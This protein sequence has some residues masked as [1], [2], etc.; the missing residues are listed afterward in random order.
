[1]KRQ[2]GSNVHFSEPA[3]D[4]TKGGI[5]G[6]LLISCVVLASVGG[7]PAYSATWAQSLSITGAS[8]GKETVLYKFQGGAA[9][10]AAPTSGVVRDSMGNIYGTT[11]WGGS[12]GCYNGN[13]C[14]TVFKIS[15]SGTETTLYAFSGGADGATPNGGLTLD[16]NG[17]LYGITTFGGDTSA[18]TYYN[19]GCGVVFKIDKA[20]NEKVLYTFTGQG[21]GAWPNDEKL[22]IDTSGNIYGTTAI[23]G[24]FD[25]HEQPTYGCGVVFR[26]SSNGQYTVLHTF[27]G[28]PKDGYWGCSG[29]VQDARGNLYGE[30]ALGG[31]DELGTVFRVAENGKENVLHSFTGGADGSSPASGE[32]VMAADGYLYG[33]ATFGGQYGY[34][35]V[36]KMATGGAEKVLYSFGTNG[37]TDGE[38]P[39]EGVVLD[40]NGNIYGTTEYGGSSNDGTVFELAKANGF[41]ES[42]LHSFT[43]GADGGEPLGGNLILGSKATLFGDA[44]Y[45]GISTACPQGGQLGC[46][47]VFKLKLQ[48]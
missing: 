24:D 33:A 7:L 48:K 22:L 17:N 40:S 37:S 27:K 23:G 42:I 26:L 34:G 18:C 44:Q 19:S 1:M 9:D 46:G 47:V 28:E 12:T 21:D 41:A 3:N 35:V 6:G 11:Y 45:G 8:Q 32:L 4:L 20:G 31:A 25:C 2:Q 30:T 29:L 13:G 14:G 15:K 38:G 36:F 43:G 16:S 39:S 10:G 5:R